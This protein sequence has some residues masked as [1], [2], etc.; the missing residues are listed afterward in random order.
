MYEIQTMVELGYNEIMT[1]D[2][3]NQV[4]KKPLVSLHTL[5]CKLNQS[6]TDSIAAALLEKGFDV[7]QN[8]EAEAK[9]IVINTCTVTAKADRKS[10]NIINRAIRNYSTRTNKKSIVI[11]TGCFVGSER[12]ALEG[13]EIDYII[14]NSK[15]KYVPDIIESHESGQILNVNSLKEDYFGYAPSNNIFHTRSNLKI[16]D[17]CDNFCTFCI[18]PMV[19]GVAQS[20]AL[21]DIMQDARI[22]A[23]HGTKEIVLTGVNMSRYASDNHR[24][25]DVLEAL[26]KLPNNV[27]I[28]ISSLEPDMLD[29][30]FFDLLKHPKMCPHLHLCLQSGSD[31]ILLKMRRMYNTREYM[32]AI[33]KIKKHIPNIN[34][35]SDVIV[36]FPGETDEDFNQTQNIITAC[37]FS[38]THI[39]PY[40]HRNGTRASRMEGE[41]SSDIKK[42]R[43]AILE[44][45]NREQKNSYR[46]QSM[47]TKQNILI[48]K[49]AK[50]EHLAVASGFSEY[51]I[52]VEI[53]TPHNNISMLSNHLNT[54]YPATITTH[55]MEKDEVVMG[56]VFCNAQH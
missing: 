50:R 47:N 5:G 38:H 30:K 48:E 43:I 24:F 53:T 29:D 2:T 18:I 9:Y 42:Q 45:I 52:P 19:R 15:K 13:M 41:V 54:I 17:G 31:R 26:L 8:I 10:R 6:E 3:L 51:Y 34:L 55:R 23:E 28:R 11:V 56:L 35:T 21:E 37:G 49:V 33:E 1:D 7:S 25:S 44:T 40:S 14:D 36:G 46:L 39:F 12:V 22:M 16:Q 32:S 4:P 20:R 27:R